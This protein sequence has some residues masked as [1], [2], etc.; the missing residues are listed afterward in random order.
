MKTFLQLVAIAIAV[1]FLVV[2]GLRGIVV[3]GANPEVERARAHEFV[4]AAAS[5][6]ERWHAESGEYPRD[7]N[8]LTATSDE[9]GLV[10]VSE[11]FGGI[12]RAPL[13]EFTAA[14]EAVQAGKL[15]DPWGHPWQYEVDED[16]E[17]VRLRSLGADGA[18]GGE[19]AMADVELTCNG[20]AWTLPHL[21]QDPLW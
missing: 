18:L 4:L 5:E 21:G 16:A 19:G 12:F 13:G 14:I 17:R 3:L 6:L 15:L 10:G 9:R 20:R 7:L 8:V 1:L 2:L 11:L